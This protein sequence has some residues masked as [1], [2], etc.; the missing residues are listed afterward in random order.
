MTL[1]AVDYRKVASSSSIMSLM[2]N[3]DRLYGYAD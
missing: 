3:I 2:A 1:M